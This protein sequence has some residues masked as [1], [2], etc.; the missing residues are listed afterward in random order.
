VKKL[1]SALPPTLVLVAMVVM[2][3]V[4]PVP[5]VIWSPG[6][7][8]DMSGQVRGHPLVEVED[9]GGEDKHTE[10]LTGR[11][12]ATSMEQSSPTSP[13]GLVGLITHYFQGNRTVMPADGVHVLGQLP[14]DSGEAR[15]LEVETSNEQAMAAGAHEAGIIVEQWPKIITVRANGPAHQVLF[16]GDLIRAI[17][18]T[19]MSTEHDVRLYLRTHKRV[20]GQAVVSI[21][22]GE[23]EIVVTISKLIGSPSD[24]TVASM[25]VTVGTGY[26]YTPEVVF[27][28]DPDL[29]DLAQ[30][31]PLALTTTMRLAEVDLTHSMVIAAVGR[32][33]ADGEITG[34]PGINEHVQ[35]AHNGRATVFLMPQENCSDMTI[36]VPGM[37]IVPVETLSQTIDILQRWGVDS[38]LPTC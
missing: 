7:S 22:R 15:R 33:S 6:Q 34:V 27:H 32:V 24:S 5:Y 12:L 29:G 8:L 21:V 1:R 14:G 37:L 18:D 38:A 25:G 9:P 20:G 16:P 35:S 31:L 26:I 28:Q 17:D 4:V 23:E 2:V 10:A 36:T 30:G 13:R 11:I 19:P 3:T